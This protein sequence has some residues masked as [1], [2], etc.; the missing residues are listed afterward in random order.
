[1]NH[2][3]EATSDLTARYYNAERSVWLFGGVLLIARFVGLGPS[4]TLPV[5]N[6]TLEKQQYFPL[7]LAVLLVAATLYMRVEWQQSSRQARHS[8]MA[9]VR[10]ATTIFWACASLWLSYPVFTQGTRFAS[11]SPAWYLGFIAIGSLI[12][13]IASAIVFCSHMIRTQTEANKLHLP[14][15]PAATRAQYIVW[16]PVI[17]L[18]LTGY[19]MLW[20]LSPNA[21]RGIA[22]LLVG[23]PCLLMLGA[24]VV[25]LYFGQ[26]EHGQRIPYAKRRAQFR[27]AFDYHDYA[28]SLIDYGDKTAREVNL[29]KSDMPQTKQNALRERY[30]IAPSQGPIDF[31][32]QLLEK[33]ELE[34]YPKDGNPNNKDPKNCGVRV[35]KRSGKKESLRVLFIPVDPKYG[36]RELVIAS[37]VVEGCAEDYVGSHVDKTKLTF[38]KLLSYAINQ[39]VIRSMIEQTGPLLH[40]LVESGQELE[41]QKLLKQNVDVNERAEAGWTPLLYASA[42]GYPSIARLLLDSGANPDIGNV[43]GITPLMYS[44]RYGNLEMC[45]LL[46]E[47]G[48]SLNLQDVHGDTALM[49]ATR[50]GNPEVAECLIIAG[51]ELGIRNRQSLTALDYAYS[52]KQGAIAKMIRKSVSKGLNHTDDP[53]G[54][55]HVV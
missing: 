15:V 10:T 53:R 18:L 17:G 12:G 45:K 16:I 9:Q 20:H 8:F 55:S 27:A 7:I 35:C 44:A 52:S 26:D 22:P 41:I 28:Y 54:S 32:V 24:E 46:I 49:V 3:G 47:Y 31:H 21:I 25:S 23:V 6:V 40:R 48:A 19:Y 14:R 30:S 36:K 34:F 33:M 11:I 29:S 43:K 50:T 51:A 4:Q 13:S 37:R 42:Q 38:Q 2:T 5:L 1:M 39:A